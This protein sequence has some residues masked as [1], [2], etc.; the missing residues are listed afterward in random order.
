MSFFTILSYFLQVWFKNR[1]AKCRQQQQQLQQ[2]QQHKSSGNN[3]TNSNS[4]SASSNSSTKKK[5]PPT[6]PTA[7]SESEQSNHN[8]TS[9]SPPFQQPIQQNKSSPSPS[10]SPSDQINHLGSVEQ[11][12]HGHMAHNNAHMPQLPTPTNGH[13]A[14]NVTN[15]WSPAP[16]SPEPTSD[17]TVALVGSMSSLT[18]GVLPMSSNS[19]CMSVLPSSAIAHTHSPYGLPTNSQVTSAGGYHQSYPTQS[20]FGTMEAS[21]LPSMQFPTAASHG[22]SAAASMASQHH[23]NMHHAATHP[24]S[25]HHGGAQS[26]SPHAQF[27]SQSAYAYPHHHSS[28]TGLN[29]YSNAGVDCLDYKDQTPSWKFQVLWTG[30]CLLLLAICMMSCCKRPNGKF[31][32]ELT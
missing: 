4:S 11:S 29:S 6:T 32:R 14:A 9:V 26:T 31:R 23:V 3:S 13:N 2:K 27:M 16:V 19:S 28:S 8:P 10:V 24:H 21:Y 18:G 22:M 20:Y 17:T 7:S 1:R 12:T 25:H 5:S 15:I 30:C